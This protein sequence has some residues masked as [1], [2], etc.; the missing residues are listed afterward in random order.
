MLK[1][2]LV[3]IAIILIIWLLVTIVSCTDAQRSK[4]TSLGNKAHVKCWSG[5]VVIFDGFSTGKVSS[6]ESSDGYYFKDA[7]DGM[8]KEASGDCIITYQ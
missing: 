2:L 7:T 1:H 4:I 3:A 5:G 8:L 6:E